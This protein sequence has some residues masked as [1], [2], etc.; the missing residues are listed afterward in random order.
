MGGI[1]EECDKAKIGNE[2]KYVSINEMINPKSSFTIFF[3][4]M[5]PFPPIMPV[6]LL[7]SQ[8]V[9]NKGRPIWSIG[10]MVDDR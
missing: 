4:D 9:V 2:V 10:E 8:L 7:A 1:N 3:I 6:V 5:L